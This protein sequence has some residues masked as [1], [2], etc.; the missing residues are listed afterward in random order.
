MTRDEIDALYRRESGAILATLIRRLG[1]FDVAEEALHEAFGAALE[2]W[3]RDGAPDEPVAW[4][5]Q[6]AKHKAIDRLRRGTLYAEKL[7]A[8]AVETAVDRAAAAPD[9]PHPIADDLL[10]L[11]FTCC[12]PALPVE[13]QLALALRTLGG[14]TTEEIARA[15]VVPVP[16]MAQRLVRAKK[17]IRDAR[18]P[19]EVPT[20]DELPERLDAVLAVV[21]L[22]F[23][24]GHAAT[25]GDAPIRADLCAEAIRL[26]RLLIRLFAEHGEARA[27]LAL[28]L[29]T[30]ARRA[31]RLDADGD[32]VPLEEQDR[33]RWSSAGIAE[34]RAQLEAVVRGGTLGPYGLQAAIAAV[35]A[36]ATRA[37]DTAWDEIARLY[38]LLNRV[39]PSPVV[40]LN[41]A[42]AVAMV[43][44]P[45]RALPMLDALEA[46]GQ[47][48]DY[49][50]LAAARADLLRRAG[51]HAD[52]AVSYRRA[53]ALAGNQ[54]ER[55]FLERRLREVTGDAPAGPPSASDRRAS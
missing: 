40:E 36:R 41:R 37:E 8:L 14:L 12:H 17:R 27:L 50:L 11:L 3:P 9:D 24:E 31:A 10:R 46:G 5:V 32:V 1:D 52:A 45:D 4:L 34:G 47:L 48:A 13:A 2:Q 35:H 39:A 16:T 7:G 18:I 15:F 23:T 28:L 53:I 30:D 33:T 26:A 19:Y 43:D 42:I 21:Y 20:A 25:H 38:A 6:T 54:G 51:R 44:G 22:V 49:H 29:L 55:R